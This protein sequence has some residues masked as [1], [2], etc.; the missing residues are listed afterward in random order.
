MI[1]NKYKSPSSRIIIFFVPILGLFHKQFITRL[2]HHISSS[3]NSLFR[4]SNKKLNFKLSKEIDHPIAHS[5][6]NSL[7]QSLIPTNLQ[8]T[9]LSLLNPPDHL[10]ESLS[11]I[12][13]PSSGLETSNIDEI[14]PV[15]RQHS[16]A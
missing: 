5:S 1:N 10:L 2:L 16:S 9:I 11:Q 13:S 6:T 12:L 14:S 7:D 15:Y 3:L 8:I 4:I